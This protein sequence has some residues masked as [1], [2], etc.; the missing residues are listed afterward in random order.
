MTSIKFGTYIPPKKEEIPGKIAVTIG[1][2][3]DGTLNNKTNIKERQNNTKA[4]QEH[5]K[6]DKR[7]SYYGDFSNIA[8][9]YE[10]YDYQE[11][12]YI[13]GIGTED[14]QEDVQSGYA[15]G[16]GTTG[17]RAKVKKGHDKIIEKFIEIKNAN[18]DIDSIS[19]LTLDVY[20]FSRG[21]AAARNFVAELTYP[22]YTPTKKG[23]GRNAH[24]VN[25]FNETVPNKEIPKHGYFGEELQQQALA[26]D[27]IRIR[28]LGIFDT[29]SSFHP[30]FS[31][32]P[33]FSN[34]VD[35]LKLNDTAKVNK[36]VHFLATD[37]HRE[38]FPL[39]HISGFERT[40]PGVHS[41]IG[42]GYT[43]GV[44]IVDELETSW[45]TSSKLE[46]VKERLIQQSWYEPEQLNIIPDKLYLKL[47]GTRTLNNTYSYI[48]LHFM[49]RISK[50]HGS[51]IKTNL[52]ENK[53]YSINDD[54]LLVRVK[55]RL[56][57]YV[58]GEGRPYIFKKLTSV[59]GNEDALQAQKDLRELRKK[60]L[61]WSS[62]R[63]WIGMDPDK[64]SE[65]HHIYE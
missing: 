47:T 62:D 28:F 15:F 38:H 10:A 44:E 50:R 48:P 29:V 18:K 9:L 57:S 34:D 45:T 41:D 46:T 54:S 25:R 30:N 31:V 55:K 51:K 33:N 7:S 40:F 13:E 53:S 36:I 59:Q 14:K 1:I 11:R 17:I 4:F 39:T 61:H 12:V 22:A 21:A 23:S 19:T 63:D 37:E 42:G 8:R 64:N 60:Y 52:L 56:E 5:G 16:S 24:Y 49:A 65:R 58:F 2:F 27:L 32:S 6:D 26:V 43:E 35:E 3:F 20:G